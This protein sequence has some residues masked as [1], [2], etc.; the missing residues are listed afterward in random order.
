MLPAFT[1]YR[2]QCRTLFRAWDLL[3][4]LVH[5][6]P[7]PSSGRLCK[8][9]LCGRGSRLASQLASRS[10]GYVQIVPHVFVWCFDT[11][12]CRS[13]PR[14]LLKG[15]G[16]SRPLPLPFFSLFPFFLPSPSEVGLFKPARV[17]GGALAENEF[18][19]L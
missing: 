14:N 18:S 5:S 2:G 16:P 9:H 6:L 17:S 11:V 13:G 19:A 7:K 3:P 15:G 8:P 4:V 10:L 12:S 1:V